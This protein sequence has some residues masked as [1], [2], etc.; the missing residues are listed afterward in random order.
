MRKQYRYLCALLSILMCISI[1]CIGCK[2]TSDGNSD[3]DDSDTKNALILVGD[4]APKYTI[5][6]PDSA[7]NQEMDAVKLIRAHFQKAGIE[8]TIT[9]DWKDNPVSD[10]EIV[11][12]N[13]TRDDA[14]D[15][16]DLD[17]YGL[18]KSEYVIKVSNNRIY[19]VGG[20][21]A[22][23]YAATESF[24]K[25]FF[26]YQGDPNQIGDVSSVYVPNDFEYVLKQP[27]SNQAISIA[28]KSLSEFV[29]SYDNSESAAKLAKYAQKLQDFFGSA[30][31]DRPE[32]VGSA[33]N[34]SAIVLSAV[35]ANQ[36]LFSAK[37]QN[38]NLMITG[39]ELECFELGLNRF[40]REKLSAG[41]TVE[42]RSDFSYEINLMETVSYMD[43]GA[44][45]DGKT[46]D[47]AAIIAT[48]EYANRYR[49]SVKA[50]AGKTFYIGV[51]AKGATIKTNTD[52][53]GASFVIDDRKVPMELRGVPIF[54]VAP[55]LESYELD[56]LKTL[57]V[58]QT[59]IGVTLPQDSVIVVTEAGT[60]RYIRKGYN[61]DNDGV[62]Q[63]EILI[64]DRNGH[65]SED[66]PVIWEYSNITSATVIPI[67]QEPLVIKGGTF[68]TVASDY[69]QISGYYKR[70]FLITRS[71]VTVEGVTHYIE[72]EGIDGAPY[73]GFMVMQECC[74]ITLKDC[75]FTPHRTYYW[76]NQS[77][78]HT[79]VGT[80]D[81]LPKRVA[82]LTLK[83]CKQSV[84]ILDQKYWG[85]IGSNLCKNIVFDECELSRFDAHMGVHNAK[86]L[87]SKLGYLGIAI[88]GSGELLV[89]NSTLYGDSLIN[90]RDDYG[91]TWN[92]NITVQ[93]CTWNPGSG[94]W[95][96]E[97]YYSIVGGTNLQQHNFGYACYMPRN[98]TIEN[99]YIDDSKAMTSYKGVWLFD[100]INPNRTSADAEL[101]LPYDYYVT[102]TVNIKG[103]T[104]ASGK[105]LHKSVNEFMFRN[106][107]VNYS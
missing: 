49:V 64:V 57:N 17:G 41:D 95:L 23:T 65:I 35:P 15:E 2:N 7:D 107:V 33:A 22:D 69:V 10:Y 105:T 66:S 68:T 31:G 103:L 82:N 25:Q 26:G 48:H 29:I 98:I 99:L 91:S 28:G 12:G 34:R 20:T 56:S 58:G 74:N 67:D 5:V 70:G 87:N 8:S 9:T 59:N 24:L 55:D 21:P 96:S 61:A 4:G 6:R 44:N 40:I 78:V 45:G 93:D 3:S 51:S 86:I 13:T 102:E 37:V 42:L 89:K 62:D 104:F 77:G 27:K 81:I 76:T 30:T 53:T 92:G 54:T 52:F 106:V 80:Y 83:N 19:I 73:D 46:D 50:D 101:S 72:N 63:N 79:S 88:T 36:G 39:G 100:N 71:N 60:K 18:S 75:V 84:D 32:I 14:D 94:K 85:I 11:V 43:F 38:G 90:L 97:E 16:I 47:L 1:V